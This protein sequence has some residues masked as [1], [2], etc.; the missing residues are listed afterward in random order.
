[1]HLRFYWTL[2]LTLNRLTE[3]A[4]SNTLQCLETLRG[5]Y[6][7]HAAGDFPQEG[8]FSRGGAHGIKSTLPR[9]EVAGGF[10]G[11]ARMDSRAALLL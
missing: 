6:S 3:I 7:R 9:V 10:A 8:R 2:G 11:C 5:A 4:F 1:M